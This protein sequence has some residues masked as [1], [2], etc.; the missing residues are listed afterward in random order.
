MYIY[1]HTRTHTHTHIYICI[2]LGA[3]CTAT[4]HTH[5]QIHT[6]TYTRNMHTH[7]YTHTHTHTT[8]N[9]QKK[10]KTQHGTH[11]HTHTNSAFPKRLFPIHP[12][13][14]SM[15]MPMRPLALHTAVH[16]P[17]RARTANM[18]LVFSHIRSSPPTRQ[19]HIPSLGAQNLQSIFLTRQSHP[20][21]R[22]SNVSLITCM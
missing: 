1:I 7:T 5:M 22:I 18:Q 17:N 14:N 21:K 8:K 4:V 9:M 19:T 10:K 3:T 2:G 11:T 15:Y 6:H 13:L 12:A 16:G 20:L